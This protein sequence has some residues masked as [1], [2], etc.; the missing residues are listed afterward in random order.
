MNLSP[1]TRILLLIVGVFWITLDQE[2]YSIVADLGTDFI[3]NI[4]SG[5]NNDRIIDKKTE[6]D[7][8]TNDEEIVKAYMNDDMCMFEF[9]L[10][11]YDTLLEAM[12][13][14]QKKSNIKKIPKDLPMFFIS[15]TDDPVGDYSKGVEK[16]YD[17]MCKASIKDVDIMLYH[18][19]RHEM[20]NEII[21][22]SVY[23][24][25]YNWIKKHI[26]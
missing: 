22:D 9:T 7:W 25:V 11:G 13:F 24:D 21:R 10:N 23:E 1:R 6:V 20:L 17:D 16:A 19:G 4:I 8:L 3:T 14:M 15:G 12:E 26:K 5:K 18:G 2:T